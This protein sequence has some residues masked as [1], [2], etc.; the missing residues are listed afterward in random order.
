MDR[1]R[2]TDLVPSADLPILMIG[3]GAT[4]SNV[5]FTLA[6][7]GFSVHII[8]PDTA[9]PENLAAGMFSTKRVNAPKWAAIATLFEQSGGERDRITGERREATAADVSA[10]DGAVIVGVDSIE[11]RRELW[12]RA[13]DVPQLYIDGR[14]GGHKLTVYSVSGAEQYESYNKSLDL[15]PEELPCGSKST[16]YVVRI[17]AGFIVNSVVRFVN[18]DPVVPYVVAEMD[19]N[20]VFVAK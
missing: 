19:N 1:S 7:M 3:G 10:W 17:L 8:D 2:Q 5:A 11:V 9:K 18:G 13:T 20:F 16:A 15:E 12:R 6:Q 4:G 14:M